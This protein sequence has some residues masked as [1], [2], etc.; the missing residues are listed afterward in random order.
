MAL[1]SR[2]NRALLALWIAIAAVILALASASR[3]YLTYA[4]F[5]RSIPLADALF[6]GF[7]DWMIWALLVFPILILAERFSLRSAGIPTTILVHVGIGVGFA[8]IQ[9]VAFAAGSALI[10]EV[11]FGVSS[12]QYELRSGFLIRFQSGL[13]IYWTILLAAWFLRS[14]RRARQEE[15]RSARLDERL[16]AVT[17]RLRPHFLFNTLNGITALLARDPARA[18]RMLIALSDL[19]RRALDGREV[20]TVPLEEELD[21]LER[22]LE[23]QRMRF[24]DRLDVTIHA[25]P[26]ALRAE[27]PYLLLQ[28][29]VE[30]AVEHGIDHSD[31]TCSLTV[32]VS[33]ERGRL[34]L[35][36]RDEGSGPDAEQDELLARGIGL[37]S[38]RDRL[39]L[40]YGDRQRFEVR[41]GTEGG[42]EVRIEL[43][44]D[45]LD[46]PAPEGG[47]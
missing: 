11:R 13:M 32:N 25:Q 29:L 47:R 20:E 43:P 10:R 14:E 2:Q 27:V 34:M 16:A 42:T 22:Y 4:A 21:F 23:I 17:T 28:P 18:E 39:Q 46:G 5:G 36:V 31:G 19:L 8:L 9:L 1:D 30:N 12:F 24:G 33:R 37:S 38:T 15:V 35:E 6:T 3:L 45:A 44:L 40:L 26:E 7:L 41:R